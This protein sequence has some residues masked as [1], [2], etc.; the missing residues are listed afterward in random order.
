MGGGD[1]RF[2]LF[3]GGHDAR[4]KVCVFSPSVF[5]LLTSFRQ[6]WDVNVRTGEARQRG[7]IEAH[8]F[9]IWGLVR[10]RP[11]QLFSACADSAVYCWD[12][13]TLQRRD[14]QNSIGHPNAK[15]YC[16][17]GSGDLLFTGSAD[18]TIRVWDVRAPVTAPAAILQGH[19]RS[20]WSLK[21]KL[22]GAF[23]SRL[24]HVVE[25][26]ALLGR[27]HALVLGKLRQH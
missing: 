24:A 10:L 21:V 12:P 5:L 3:S 19:T 1:G 6:V 4:L 27:S 7:D 15:I 13:E 14:G 2:V 16:L 20:V 8:R 17:A 9:T 22:C 25:D 23:C 26:G 18:R 11:E